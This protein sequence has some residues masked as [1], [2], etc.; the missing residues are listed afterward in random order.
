MYFTPTSPRLPELISAAPRSSWLG[1]FTGKT[2]ELILWL[3]A[4]LAVL[5]ALFVS[6]W[7]CSTA[8]RRQPDHR[9]LLRRLP[10]GQRIAVRRGCC[11]LL[12]SGRLRARGGGMKSLEYPVLILLA[13]P[14]W[15]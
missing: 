8:P 13:A 12:M 3:A 4:V 5:G 7:D 15:G 14:A 9:P 11:Q 6:A 2:T 1:V 10:T